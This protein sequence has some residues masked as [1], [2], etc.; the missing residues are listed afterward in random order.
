MRAKQYNSQDVAYLIAE[1]NKLTPKELDR[2]HGIIIN[3]D[4]NTVEDVINGQIFNSVT[5]WANSIYADESVIY[6]DE[7]IGKA[8]KFDDYY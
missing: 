2:L 8:S 1:V 4:T 5:E 7:R 3:S 6:E